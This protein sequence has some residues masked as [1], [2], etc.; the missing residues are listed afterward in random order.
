MAVPLVPAQIAALAKEAGFP[1]SQIAIAVAVAL[2]ESGGR[3]DNVSL[4]NKDGSKD[5][6]LWQINN[7][8]H[9]DLMSQYNWSNPH[10]NAKMAFSVWKAAGNSWKPWTVF[11]TGTY[12]KNLGVGEWAAKNPDSS[13]IPVPTAP[14]TTPNNG[15]GANA[16]GAFLAN[17]TRAPDGG[18]GWFTRI[19]LFFIGIG[20]IFQVVKSIL[21]RSDVVRTVGK[22]AKTAAVIAK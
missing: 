17:A 8:A 20:V 14:G 6:G 1:S 3:P 22:V 16:N 15:G 18:L 13:G 11:N 5:Y 10:D 2:A 7:H 19:V 21:N 4:P 9:S 12:S